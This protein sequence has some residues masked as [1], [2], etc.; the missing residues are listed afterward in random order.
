MAKLKKASDIDLLRIGAY[1]QMEGSFR[2]GIRNR[3]DYRFMF[4]TN[5]ISDMEELISRVVDRYRKDGPYIEFY[6][7]E[8]YEA[9][10]DMGFRTFMQ[11]DWNVPR[12]VMRSHS[13]KYEY[14]RAAI[15]SLG[16]VDIDSGVPYIRLMS[17][18]HDGL[19]MMHD[20]YG[21]TLLRYDR[22]SYLQWKGADAMVLMESLNW[23][24]YCYR[25]IRG[26]ELVK[27]V[28]WEL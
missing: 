22:S 13:L 27:G 24:F 14:L 26:A 17:V 7:K 2:M 15:D 19:S 5:Q 18:N 12:C 3:F 11:Y 23:R 16:D 21:G 10:R 4:A 1:A 20:I 9:L 8:L 28:R 25:N 6:S